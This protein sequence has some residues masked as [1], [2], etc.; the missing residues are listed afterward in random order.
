MSFIGLFLIITACVNFINLATAQALRRSKEVGIKKVLGSLRRSLFWQFI[1]ETALIT[2][3]ATILAFGA[4]YLLLPSVNAWFRSQISIDIL[5]DWQLL[6]FTPLLIILVTFLA[7][8]YPGLIL[9]GFRPIAAL[10][11]KLSMQQ[12]GEVQYSQGP[13]RYPVQYFIDPDHQHDRDHKA[14]AIC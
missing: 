7:G 10:K 8:F 6:V 11:G 1:A 4:S 12:I 14:D 5:N 9:S 2:I 13:Y 3:A